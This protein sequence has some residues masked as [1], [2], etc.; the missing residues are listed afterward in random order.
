MVNTKNKYYLLIVP[1]LLI[2]LMSCTE[3]GTDKTKIYKSFVGCWVESDTSGKSIEDLSIRK[4]SLDSGNRL[5]LSQYEPGTQCR[6]WVGINEFEVKGDYLYW[7]EFKAKVAEDNKTMQLDYITPSGRTIPFT[8]LRYEKASNFMTKLETS[9]AKSYSYSIP[10]KMND[11]LTCTALS[12]VNMDHKKIESVV[13]N[14]IDGDYDDIHSILIY[15]DGNLALEEYFNDKGKLHSE[16]I[17][18]LYCN[19]VHHLS[20]VTKSVISALV[21]IAIDKGY[22]RDI[23]EPIYKYFPEYEALFDSTKKKILLKHV[24]TMST[25]LKWDE[26]TYPF[27]DPRNSAYQWKKSPDNLGFYLARDLVSAPGQTFNYSGGC[28]MLLAEIIHRTTGLPVD[29]FAEKHLFNPLGI[30]KYKWL[31]SDTLVTNHSGGLALRPRD[32]V[33]IG[34]LFLDDGRWGNNQIISKDWVMNSSR[35]QISVGSTGY[36]YQWWMRSFQA[37][38][39]KMNSFYAIGLD[40][41]FIIVIRELN[42]VLVFTGANFG[43]D[44][45][46]NVYKI[47]EKYI[48]AATK[49]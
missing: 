16:F 4:F 22:I 47:I 26:F 9:V 20:S 34:K 14:I 39:K 7:Y 33:K 37:D 13:N 8:L 17:N 23:N 49:L 40:G 30:K 46:S 18:N 10:V 41:Q 38:G 28:M 36:G 31:G 45:S 11:G 1:V 6:A 3:E 48:I 15:K 21:G 12:N 5:L 29:R 42:M 27:S 35:Q 19:R 44:W 32:M 25:G 24:L 2:S 43:D